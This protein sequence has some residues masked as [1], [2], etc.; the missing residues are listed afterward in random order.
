MGNEIKHF[1]AE[2]VSIWAKQ[3]W[4]WTA[5]DNVAGVALEWI[6]KTNQSRDVKVTKKSRME[7]KKTSLKMVNQVETNTILSTHGPRFIHCQFGQIELKFFDHLNLQRTAFGLIMMIKRHC[8]QR[9]VILVI[10][11]NQKYFKRIKD[12]ETLK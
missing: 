2:S 7:R 12:S 10:N 4:Q 11:G 5:L 3:M 8:G 6:H 9:F 1:A